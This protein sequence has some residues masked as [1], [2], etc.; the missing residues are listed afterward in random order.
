[1]DIFKSNI[2]VGFTAALVGAALAPVLLPVMAAAARPLAK[3]LIRGGV[4][5]YEKSREA[6]AGAGEMIEDLVAEVH[7]EL[8]QS[9]QQSGAA[10]AASAGNEKAPASAQEG[11]GDASN[12]P[13]NL[14]SVPE[15]DEEAKG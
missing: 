7:A 1:M 13:R 10:P 6:V 12:R 9:A 14:S 2:V 8:D 4:M 3:S 11:N 5:M 15:R